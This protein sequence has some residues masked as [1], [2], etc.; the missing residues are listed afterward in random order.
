MNLTKI[1]PAAGWIKN[2][3]KSWLNY[4]ISAGLTIGVMLIPQGMAYAMVAGLPP[5]YGLYAALVPLFIYA[6]F[7]TSRYL[8]VGP[9]AIVAI[10]V[11]ASILPYAEHGSAEAVKYAVTL[12]FLVGILQLSMGVFR[13]GFIVNFLS[14][15]VLAAFTS[16]A[17]III[18]F[19]Q[20]KHVFGLD[21]ESSKFAHEIVLNIIQNIQTLHFPSMI[22]AV[23]A[24]A[25]IFLIKKYK[26]SFPSFLIVVVLGISIVYMG[27][28]HQDGVK[29]LGEVPSGMPPFTLPLWSELLELL[30]IAFSIALIGFIES[31]AIAKKLSENDSDGQPKSNQEFISMGLSNLGGSFFSSFPVAGGFSRSTVNKEAGAKTQLS[32]IIAL[33]MVLVTLLFLTDMFFY[34]PKAILATIVIFAV[35]GLVDF[36]TPLKLMK[37][38]KGDIF[39]WIA[40]F[41]VTLSMGILYGILIGALI[42]LIIIIFRTTQPHFVE[43]GRLPDTPIFRNVKRYENCIKEPGFVVVRFDGPLYFANHEYFSENLFEKIKNNADVEYVVLDAAGINHV[44]STAFEM[45]EKV[46]AKL[47]EQGIILV[48]TSLIGPVSDRMEKAGFID[49]MG[50]ENFYREV[51]EA[52]LDISENR[53]KSKSTIISLKEEFLK[54]K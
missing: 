53:M 25:L 48:I 32:S 40:T 30:P 17:A 47:K 23:I 8:S 54:G 19:S 46:T 21:M 45:L 33:A 22:T 35:I 4:D 24:F 34:L 31:I 28:L 42:S 3:K 38:S 14:H 20:L 15:P 7:G 2:Y 12:S 10:L 13:L 6:V 27:N 44:D 18:A 37:L 11:G 16:A 36:K 5:I 52:I 29:V 50:E 39:I 1:I 43:L 51:Y 26:K 41:L 9:V 49:F